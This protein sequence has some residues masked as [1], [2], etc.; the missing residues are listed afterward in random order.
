[1]KLVKVLLFIMTV[2]MLYCQNSPVYDTLLSIHNKSNDLILTDAGINLLFAKEVAY[3]LSGSRDLSLYK[4]YASLNTDNNRLLLAY[5]ISLPKKQPNYYI[6]KILTFGLEADLND[7][8]STLIKNSEFTNNIGVR[9]KFT[10]MRDGKVNSSS[11]SEK[12]HKEKR[13]EVIEKIDKTM[14]VPS[15]VTI[16][17]IENEEIKKMEYK[18]LQDEATKKLYEEEVDKFRESKY[19][20]SYNKAWVTFSFFLPISTGKFSVVDEVLTDLKNEDTWLFESEILLNYFRKTPRAKFLATIGLELNNFNS[21]LSGDNTE[22]SQTTIQ[23]FNNSIL[24]S[25]RKTIFMGEFNNFLASGIFIEFTAFPDFFSK[26]RNSPIGISLEINQQYDFLNE[27]TFPMTYKIGIPV[28]LKDK[29][30]APKINFEPQV[31]FGDEDTLLGI[32][33][34]LPFGSLVY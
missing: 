7:G 32:G 27:R 28:S 17:L 29:N 6:N 10:L 20:K 18:N 11:S 33:L 21:V 34:G 16:E 12:L 13:M 31:V 22:L 9:L 19:Y 15:T 2:N 23:N 4:S 1:M 14:I 30:G 26:K 5:N 8:I 24:S 25:S 3:F